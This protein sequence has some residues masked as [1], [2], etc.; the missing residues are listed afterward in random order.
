MRYGSNTPEITAFLAWL[1]AAEATQV[2]IVLDNTPLRPTPE[3]KAA[4]QRNAA[5]NLPSNVRSALDHDEVPAHRAISK[6]DPFANILENRH[7]WTTVRIALKA[8]AN[9]GRLDSAD[10]DLILEPFRAAGFVL[11]PLAG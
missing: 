4:I 9:R 8:L 3:R 7:F 6:L 1:E 10:V 2:R 5:T 11:G